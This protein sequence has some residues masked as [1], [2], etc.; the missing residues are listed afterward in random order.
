MLKK[1]LPIERGVFCPAFFIMVHSE[2]M[3][4]CQAEK[5]AVVRTARKNWVFPTRAGKHPYVSRLR[6]RLESM[7]NL[8]FSISG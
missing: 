6:M 5:P 3:V 7:K 8:M 1:H 2:S 4:G